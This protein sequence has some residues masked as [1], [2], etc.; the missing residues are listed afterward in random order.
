MEHIFLFKFYTLPMIEE[1]QFKDYN[2]LC[3]LLQQTLLVGA[4]INVTLYLT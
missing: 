3:I 4:E 1:R 2:K